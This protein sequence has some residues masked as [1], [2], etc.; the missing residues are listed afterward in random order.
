MSRG[1]DHL[2]FACARQGEEENNAARLR[3]TKPLAEGWGAKDSDHPTLTSGINSWTLLS[4]GS[5]TQVAGDARSQLPCLSASSPSTAETFITITIKCH[6]HNTKQITQ[7]WPQS[8]TFGD[9]RKSWC[10]GNGYYGHEA[11]RFDLLYK[12]FV[13]WDTEPCGMLLA[14][15]E[16][17]TGR[18]LGGNADNEDNDIEHAFTIVAR[19]DEDTAAE[20][21]NW[22]PGSQTGIEYEECSV[23]DDQT[24]AQRTVEAVEDEVDV[25]HGVSNDQP[26]SKAD[27][28]KV[29]ITSRLPDATWWEFQAPVDLKVSEIKDMWQTKHLLENDEYY[30]TCKRQL[31]R[32]SM[33]CAE[34]QQTC[35]SSGSGDVWIHERLHLKIMAG[36]ELE[37]MFGELKREL[38]FQ[39]GVISRRYQKVEDFRRRLRMNKLAEWPQA[40]PNPVVVYPEPCNGLHIGLGGDRGMKFIVTSRITGSKTMTFYRNENETAGAL[41]HSWLSNQNFGKDFVEKIFLARRTQTIL[42]EERLWYMSSFGRDRS[43]KSCFYTD[44]KDRANVRAIYL[45]AVTPDIMRQLELGRLEPFDEVGLESRAQ[46]GPPEKSSLGKRRRTSSSGEGER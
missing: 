18:T 9:I 6:T 43:N 11:D 31:L 3:L 33:T 38:E 37:T 39:T 27:L 16:A 30:L 24:S 14:W 20:Q 13:L 41:L 15:K 44:E 25:V 28:I 34:I 7:A 42:S 29:L 46:T 17:D 21:D 8:Q 2:A 40:P 10:V 32:D 22:S 45:E 4:A 19:E 5:P 1:P 26:R 36:H 23:H 12:D 35:M